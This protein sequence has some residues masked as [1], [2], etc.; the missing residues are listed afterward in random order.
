MLMCGEFLKRPLSEGVL[1]IGIM[2]MFSL[3]RSLR[4][5]AQ[6]QKAFIA[7]ARFL[8]Q[9]NPG[10]ESGIFL[11]NKIVWKDFNYFARST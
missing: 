6:R 2:K 4:V 5:M 9:K 7:F 1:P 8:I 10:R 11:Y 3:R